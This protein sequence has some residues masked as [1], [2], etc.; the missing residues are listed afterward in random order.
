MTGTPESRWVHF[1]TPLALSPMTSVQCDVSGYVISD[2]I[3]DHVET[4]HCGERCPDGFKPYT[5][6]FAELDEVRAFLESYP[7]RSQD[8]HPDTSLDS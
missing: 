8:S 4:R 5:D 7:T 3:M 1:T 2:E 6:A